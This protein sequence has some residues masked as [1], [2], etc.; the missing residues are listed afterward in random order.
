MFTAL[1]PAL[2]L[3]KFD[4]SELTDEGVHRTLSQESEEADVDEG[5]RTLSA[6]RSDPYSSNQHDTDLPPTGHVRVKAKYDVTDLQTEPGRVVG[7]RVAR[8][9]A[10]PAQQPEEHLSEVQESHRRRSTERVTS[11]TGFVRA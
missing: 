1:P 11:L 4:E 8:A 9:E 5:K 6:T 3:M 10:P 7:R 2:Q